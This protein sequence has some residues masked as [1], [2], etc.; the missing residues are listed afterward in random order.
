MPYVPAVTAVMAWLMFGESLDAVAVAGM[1]LG[2]GLPTTP[3]YIVMVALF[4][5]IQSLQLPELRKAV[6][7]EQWAA[8]AAAVQRKR[9]KAAFAFGT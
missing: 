4:I 5:R 7:A 9:P 8:G 6:E 3:S 1:V 2:L